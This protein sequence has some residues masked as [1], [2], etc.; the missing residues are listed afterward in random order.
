MHFKDY[1]QSGIT[2]AIPTSRLVSYETAS[3]R[4]WR[5]LNRKWIYLE[6]YIKVITGFRKAKPIF[7]IALRRRMHCINQRRRCATVSS[8]S[9]YE[10]GNIISL[11]S[12]NH[13]PK[14]S[15]ACMLVLYV[16]MLS[17][18]ARNGVVRQT[19]EWQTDR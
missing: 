17:V 5:H 10:I 1:F 6:K 11:Y 19:A 9:G 16:G 13:R 7:T 18:R 15:T 2:L 14:T 8:N 12:V 4:K 3:I